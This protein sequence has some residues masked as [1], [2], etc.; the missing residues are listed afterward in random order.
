MTLTT[1]NSQNC[2]VIIAVY[3]CHNICNDSIMHMAVTSASNVNILISISVKQFEQITS[4][5]TDNYLEL[6]VSGL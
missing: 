6:D 3:V 1:P 2:H 5:F 4:V